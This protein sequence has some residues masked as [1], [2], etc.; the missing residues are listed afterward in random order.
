ERN[1]RA[2]LGARG[3]VKEGM[4]DDA[5]L[6][7]TDAGIAGHEKE[8]RGEKRQRGQNNAADLELRPPD[9]SLTG[10][11]RYRNS[12]KAGNRDQGTGWGIGISGIPS[13]SGIGDTQVQQFEFGTRARSVVIGADPCSLIPVP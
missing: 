1:R 3:V 12:G 10:H 4:K 7:E 2:D 9:L 11:G 5:L 13:D 6:E 8:Q